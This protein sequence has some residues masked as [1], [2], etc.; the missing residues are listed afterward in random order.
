ML[1]KNGVQWEGF[2]SD[3]KE[4]L[5]GASWS[6]YFKGNPFLVFGHKT[7]FN[8]ALKNKVLDFAGED[9]C[10]HERMFDADSHLDMKIIAKGT[11]FPTGATLIN[12]PMTARDC[13]VNAW[14]YSQKHNLS[15]C[16]GFYM[17]ASGLWRK[18]AWCV[19]FVMNVVETTK[20]GVAYW[21]VIVEPSDY[22]FYKKEYI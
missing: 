5:S 8:L 18:H 22:D 1:E 11:S 19:D 21:G 15:L 16:L 2:D 3:Y 4:R 13:F 14:K 10:L 9:V 17:D 12:A 20:L 6:I 7:M